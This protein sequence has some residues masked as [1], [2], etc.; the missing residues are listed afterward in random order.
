MLL[1]LNDLQASASC[2]LYALPIIESS[3]SHVLGF[4]IDFGGGVSVCRAA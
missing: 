4:G 1:C 3:Q 2:F